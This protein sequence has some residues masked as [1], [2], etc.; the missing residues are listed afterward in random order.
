MKR[1]V[2]GL[3]YGVALLA[4]S[5]VWIQ[6]H[7]SIDG[8]VKPDGD[9][10]DIPYNPVLYNVTV[11]FG[12]PALEQPAD[13]QMTNAGI[14]LGR[15]LFFDPILSID[16]TVSCASCHK[17]SASFTDN[18][19]FSMGVNNGV[20]ARGAMSL[21][22]V[23]FH[24]NGFFWDGRVRTLEEQALKPVEVPIEMGE[25]WTHVEQ[26]LKRHPL[27]P[28]DFRKA[29]G[30]QN[31]SEIT[32]DLATKAIAQFERSLI[33]GG[34]TKYDRFVKGEIFL[35]ENEYSGYLMYFNFEPTL[36]DAQCGHCHNAPL[37]ASGDY[38]N[39]GLQAAATLDDF[40]DKG[41][42]AI[43]GKP[44]DNGKFKVPTLRNIV[45]T[46]PYMHDGRFKT[47]KEVIDHYDSGGK[48]SPNKST[49]LFPIHLTPQQKADLL[50]FI[51]TLT[52]SSALTNPAF[53]S[54][55]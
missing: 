38:F 1:R 35:D 47:L 36:P 29:F 19:E 26:K 54:P 5:V 4:I 49:F 30:I 46:A 55:F 27:Y 28:A 3:K 13:N 16:S 6:C 25:T 7:D 44:G 24:Y 40:A 17:P 39:N 14:W 53:Q 48:P 18:L 50:A 52:D 2:K 22:N 51:M 45:F 8:P 12:F 20:T 23:G 10:T 34:N 32:K 42:G 43:T 21:I 9:L 41:L 15:K 11:P 37:F 33:C 31:T